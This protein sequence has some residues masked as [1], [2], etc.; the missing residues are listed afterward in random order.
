MPSAAKDPAQFV[1]AQRLPQFLERPDRAQCTGRFELDFRLRLG[2]NGRCAPRGLQQPVDHRIEGSTDLIQASEGGDG[3]LADAALVIAERL[4]ERAVAPGT[5]DR[6]LDVRH[7][8]RWPSKDFH[9]NL[10][11]Q[12]RATTSVL[13]KT[14]ENPKPLPDLPQKNDQK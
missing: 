10:R 12:R 9:K 1:K 5:G 7:Q 2:P 14:H 8:D 6:D 3:A 4:D 11:T 13:A